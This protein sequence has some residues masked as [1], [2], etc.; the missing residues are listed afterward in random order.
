MR[1]AEQLLDHIYFLYTTESELENIK[2]KLENHV[3]TQIYKYT[4]FKGVDGKKELQKEFDAY[5]NSSIDDQIRRAKRDP[6][7]FKKYNMEKVISY[8]NKLGLADSNKSSQK[9]YKRIK[10]IGSL[11]HIYS[12]IKILEDAIKQKYNRILIIESDFY[13]HRDFVNK[14]YQC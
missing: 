8:I 13:L 11:G 12:F 3:L 7:L 9:P 1:D 4:F 6:Y 2:Y 14:L 5:L 10:S